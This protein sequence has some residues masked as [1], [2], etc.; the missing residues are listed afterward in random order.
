LKALAFTP[1]RLYWSGLLALLAFR[2]WL[3]ATLP[4]TGDE[5]YFVLWGEHPA[6]GY[7]DHPPMVGWWLGGLLAISRA[8]WVLRLPALLL[9]LILSSA[10]W[11]LVRPHG[12]ERA[13]I[14]ALIVL[15]QPANV[16][17]VLITTDIPVIM[18]SMLS[19]LAYVAALRCASQSS[20]TLAWHAA[21]GALLGLAFLGKYFAA[22][23]GI[24]YLVHFLFIR[25]DAARWPGFALLLIAALPAP[26]YN[27]WWNSSHCW[28]NILFNFMNRNAEAGFS[29]QNPVLY[30][31]SLAYLATPW[32]LFELWR[33]RKK[34]LET[35]RASVE[36]SAAFWLMLVPLAL[37]A[38]MSLWRSIGLHW[39][40]A[41]IPL[42][43]VLAAIVLPQAVLPRLVRW[44]AVFAVMQ[45][46]IIVLTATLPL[47]TWKSN[48]L[49]TGIVMTVRAD[50]VL[51]HLQAYARDYLFAMEG[52]S[53][54]A[55][56]AFNAQRPFAV[57]GVGSY[58]AR[59]DDLITDW[60]AQDGRNV[61]ILLKNE[62][63]KGEYE[64]FFNHVEFDEFVVQGVRLYLVLGQGFN[65][66]V[67]HEKV[68][69]RIR[70]RFYRI[71]AWLPQRG[72][73]F[74]ERYFPE[75]K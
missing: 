57:F 2:L 23:L 16:V 56:L 36:A 58:H 33:Q 60:R 66:A 45:V 42:L 5:A 61:L 65:Y 7:Y 12:A 44:S 35:V 20:R 72:C 3:A 9:P 43:G 69:T 38:L 49:Y 51:D 19:V 74:T 24:A 11:W 64:A 40:I 48:K 63:K 54:A 4:M 50:E 6:G 31:V 28:V 47:Q 59:Q 52:Y 39:L 32:V 17:N 71:P 14:A 13:R 41:F 18:F 29:W 10:A 68:L 46:L 26:L 34:M 25:R 21:S 1:T 62:P 73:E 8:E 22:L 55:T 37:F 70:Q 30:L 53:M 27:L 15:L 67:Y 75:M